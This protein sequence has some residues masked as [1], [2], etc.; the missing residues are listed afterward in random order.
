MSFLLNALAM[1][2]GFAWG[3]VQDWAGVRPC[4]PGAVCFHVARRGGAL[5]RLR[6][7]AR[8]ASMEGYKRRGR[9]RPL[10]CAAC[11]RAGAICG[12]GIIYSL[13]AG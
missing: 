9:H 2:R 13:F 6:V 11:D 7:T 5:P 3:A 8:V 10:R 4:P 12:E 1:T